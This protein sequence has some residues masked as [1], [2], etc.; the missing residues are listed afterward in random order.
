M[1]FTQAIS[2]GFGKYVEFSGRS[3][4]SDYWFWA[5]FAFIVAVVTYAIG[6]AIG[7]QLLYIIAALAIALPGIAVAVRRLHDTGRSG[8]WLLLSIIPFGGFVVLFFMVQ[9]SDGP[10]AFGA[11]PDTAGGAVAPTG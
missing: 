10:N 4:R 7:T 9:P 8:W 1:S 3:S 2:D 6:L 5:L 11:A